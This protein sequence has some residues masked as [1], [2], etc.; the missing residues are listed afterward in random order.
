M[1]PNNH[2][3]EIDQ[4]LPSHPT[5]QGKRQ[6]KRK[7]PNDYMQRRWIRAAI[8]VAACIGLYKI[9]DLISRPP[10][11]KYHKIQERSYEPSKQLESLNYLTRSL[12]PESSAP[13]PSEAGGDN[14]FQCLSQ[15]MIMRHCDKDVKLIGK[16]DKV[17]IRDNRDRYGN[18]HCSDKGKERAMYIASLFVENDQ[19]Q[20]LASGTTNQTVNNLSENG[21]P[22]IP[23]VNATGLSDAVVMKPQ[24]PTPLKIYALNDARYNSDPAKEHQNFREVETVIP[25]ADKFHL[26]V[27][28]SFGVNQEGDL[29]MDFFTS[30][31]KSV[32]I[33]IDTAL[34]G[35][36]D[37]EMKGSN[38]TNTGNNDSNIIGLCQNG[39][40]V[41]NWKHSLIPNLAHA[42]GCGRKQGCPKK[43]QGHDFDT[44]WVITYKL[45]VLV[46]KEQLNKENH[47]W[48]K[49]MPKL[50]AEN[51]LSW[52]I[53][54]QTIQEGFDQVY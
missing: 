4:L 43:Y 52:E 15:L 51:V 23:A 19:Y 54:A 33:N 6:P 20:G 26:S 41:V 39:M 1:P 38:D 10:T 2:A 17:R 13:Q 9:F 21:A 49:H 44:V 34:H 5:D 53:S 31:S 14:V 27:D 40:T 25:L 48:L 18:G 37:P 7:Q 29:A 24:F 8:G 35:L 42:L 36:T 50:S 3:T 45:S 46:A 22:P 47:R 12:L 16:H 32:E 11:H 30:L 28:E